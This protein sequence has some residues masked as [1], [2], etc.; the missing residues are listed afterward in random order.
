[1][2]LP[3]GN[4]DTPAAVAAISVAPELLT[5]LYVSVPGRPVT[6]KSTVMSR[7]MT[8]ILSDPPCGHVRP[9]QDG[10][11]VGPGERRDLE[12][13]GAGVRAVHD[14]HADGRRAGERGREIGLAVGRK[15][16][17]RVD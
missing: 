5:T 1:M 13:H 17:L 6:P 12:L 11:R 16:G 3:A 2:P 10:D 4:S 15:C 14:R 8:D 7:V 9:L